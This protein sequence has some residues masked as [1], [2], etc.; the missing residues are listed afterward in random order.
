MLLNYLFTN[1]ME[2]SQFADV[3]GTTTDDL[4]ALIDA[5]VFPAPSYAY[6]G[7]GRSVSFVADFTDR[8]TYRF[9]LR[10]HT[11]WYRDITQLGLDTEARA[12]GHFFSRYDHAKAAFLSS[13]LGAE[14]QS[15]A[16][17]VGDQFD[18]EH[19]NSTWGHFLN[20]VYGVC[21]RDGRP[22]SVFLKQA[23]V[24]FI[25]EMIGD[26]PGTLSHE[27]TR[28]LRRTVDFLDSVESDF[29]PHEAPIASRQRCIVDVRAR[30]FGMTAA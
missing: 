24:M 28:L 7:K 3:V 2:E 18:D 23:G 9:H 8:Q 11:D 26:E 6:E 16:P 15:Q 10:G 12:R 19:A 20:G 14:L 22:E 25:E 29:A 4:H 13:P 17:T 27:K 1:F 5:K 21:T 30:F